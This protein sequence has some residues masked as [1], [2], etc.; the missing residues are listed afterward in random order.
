MGALGYLTQWYETMYSELSSDGLCRLLFGCCGIGWG[1]QETGKNGVHT[2]E[3][4]SST[5]PGPK[6]HV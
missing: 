4:E 2:R 1:K 3:I 6:L 5:L